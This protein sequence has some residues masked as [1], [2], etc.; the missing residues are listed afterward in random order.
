[1]RVGLVWRGNPRHQND[2]ERS[3]PGLHTLAPLWS[4]PGVQFISLQTGERAT[5]ELPTDAPP[6]D[7]WGAELTDFA[8]TAAALEAIDLL[9]CVDTA[10]AHLAG[11]MGR[12]C[13]VLLPHHRTDWRWQR[14][15]DDTPWYPRGMR[16]FRQPRRGDWAAVVER[17]RGVLAE[18]V[19]AGAP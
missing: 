6:I 16:L 9:V 13:W 19:K 4:V 3:M 5:A 18:H 14:G 11:A 7:A 17:V 12:P 15:R 10:M 2:A 1:M 8:D